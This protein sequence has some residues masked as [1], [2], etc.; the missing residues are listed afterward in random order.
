MTTRSALQPG[1]Y[2]DKRDLP[3]PRLTLL[4]LLSF[5]NASLTP[6]IQ[7]QS[8]YTPEIEAEWLIELTTYQE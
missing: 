3:T 8:I 1:E 2:E 7:S 5:L 6:K 4:L